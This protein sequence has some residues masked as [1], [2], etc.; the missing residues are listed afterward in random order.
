MNEVLAK[1]RGVSHFQAGVVFDI[2]T[3]S[4]LKSQ[5][6]ETQRAVRVPVF[7]IQSHVLHI[8]H[9]KLSPS[10]LRL[11]LRLLLFQCPSTSGPTHAFFMG[12]GQTQDLLLESGICFHRW[13]V[14]AVRSRCNSVA[15]L[16]QVHC[17]EPSVD[18]KVTA[19]G[20]EFEAF[21]LLYVPFAARM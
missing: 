8:Y 6:Q 13:Q 1:S 16:R 4:R 12:R 3:I 19:A 20:I 15:C 2:L 10:S 21:Q 7:F 5:H 11:F 9:A 17:G 14:A 18:F